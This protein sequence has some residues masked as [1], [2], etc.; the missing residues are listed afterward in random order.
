VTPVLLIDCHNIAHAAFHAMGE[1]DYHG[2]T[3]GVIYGFFLRV[4]TI[5]KKFNTT[6]LVFCWD[7]KKNI[8]K[9]KFAGYKDRKS[10]QVKAYRDK[11]DLDALHNQLSELRLGALPSVGFNNNL[12]YIGFEADDI[13]AA[14]IQR[15]QFPD[16]WIS[17]EGIRFVIVS[18]DKDL[19]QLLSDTVVIYNLRSN[20]IYTQAKFEKEY[21]IAPDQWASAKALGG[22]DSDTVPGI[23]GI[24]DPA[25]SK[26]SRA[27]KY[28]QG[29]RNGKW[30]DA[31]ESVDGKAIY[32]RNLE[33]VSLP[34]TTRIRPKIVEDNFTKKAFID[35]FD[36]Y[37][38]ES[39]LRKDK[40]REILDHFLTGG[41]RN[42]KRK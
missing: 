42:G 2:R 30:V 17:D 9:D 33:L 36:K 39:F 14:V 15:G 18:S 7:S 23:K 27:I 10:K 19:Y 40:L 29:E 24:A 38:F 25:K 31:I 11:L 41:G 3:T 1:L 35:T 12:C 8:R 20:S 32:E 22:C 26:G 16:S 4:F 28:L 34:I 13:I 37:G 6:K 21:H 5:A